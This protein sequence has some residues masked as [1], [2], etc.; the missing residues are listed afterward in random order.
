YLAQSL[1]RYLFNDEDALIHVDMSEY[2]E[3]FAISRLIGAPPGYVGYDEGGQLTE[4]VRR[5]PYSV[6]LL[7]EIEKAHPDVFNLLLQ[8]LDEG[9][10]TD[11]FGRKVNFKNT[12][13]IMTS[14][15]GTRD[16]SKSGG[17]G[18]QSVDKKSLRETMERRINEEMK[19][20]F[21][22]EFLNRLDETV[23][24]NPL[25]RKDI[26]SI[27][28]IEL[29]DVFKRVEERGMTVSLTPGAKALVAEKGFDQT[30]GARQLKRTIQ[31]L[32]EDPLA[33]D[34]LQGRFTEGSKIRVSKKSGGLH[35][36][37][38]NATDDVGEVLDKDKA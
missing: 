17:L 36:V 37:D 32:V 27:V 31:K 34:I 25:D 14:N 21:S 29:K 16:I 4:K 28:D 5:R 2:M 38:G 20:T 6:V 7:D 26:L 10:L 1:G 24:F 12:I 8:V 3:K 22:P 18:F 13:L 15:L 19:K 11:S 35:F 30:Y 9:R 33:E 23:V